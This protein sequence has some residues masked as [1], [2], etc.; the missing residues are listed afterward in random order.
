[1]AASFSGLPSP[2]PHPHVIDPI[3]DREDRFVD[4]LAPAPVAADYEVHQ[5]VAS[6]DEQRSFRRHQHARATSGNGLL[7]GFHPLPR[8]RNA[9]HGHR[10]PTCRFIRREIREPTSPPSPCPNR[11][12]VGR[13]W[14]GSAGRQRTSPSGGLGRSLVVCWLE[15]SSGQQ[16]TQPFRHA[17]LRS[18]VVPATNRPSSSLSAATPGSATS[19]TTPEIEAKPGSIPYEPWRRLAKR[20]AVTWNWSKRPCWIR[21]QRRGEDRGLRRDEPAGE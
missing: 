3:L 14:R 9:F 7:V 5:P 4:A 1:M 15:H 19:A 21:S 13:Q 12:D 11:L 16:D 10:H 8:H 17:P 18:I 6:L 2:L 20:R